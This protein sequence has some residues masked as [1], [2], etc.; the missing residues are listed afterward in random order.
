MENPKQK[1]KEELSELFRKLEQDF[2]PKD[3]ARLLELREQH[4]TEPEFFREWMMYD[5]LVVGSMC[6][7]H[8]LTEEASESVGAYISLK[9]APE[10]EEFYQNELKAW[11]EANGIE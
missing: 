11:K 7:G 3:E 9:Y 1:V 8:K 5:R 4:L 10:D 6:E 2:N